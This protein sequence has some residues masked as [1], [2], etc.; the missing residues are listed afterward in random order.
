[1]LRVE[2]ALVRR[3]HSQPNAIIAVVDVV[4]VAARAL[5]AAFAGKC[6]CSESR[7]PP[8]TIDATSVCPL[9][10]GV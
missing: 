5:N 9:I 7:D 6:H 4:A 3:N 8:V 1:M 10:S 2:F